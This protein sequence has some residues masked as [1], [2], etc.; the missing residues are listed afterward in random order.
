MHIFPIRFNVPRSIEFLEKQMRNDPELAK[1]E[2]RLKMLFDKFE[3][4]RQLP[5]VAVDTKG[6]YVVY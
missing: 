3:D 2:S 4:S 6:D 1:F 5:V